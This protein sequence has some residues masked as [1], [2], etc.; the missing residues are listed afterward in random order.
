MATKLSFKQQHSLS[1][2]QEVSARIRTRYPDRVPV[3]VEKAP[4]SDVPDIDK[5]K[6]LVPDITLGKFTY[7]IR[8]HINLTSEKALFFFVGGVVPPNAERMHRIYDQGKDEDGFLYMAYAGENTFG[9]D[10]IPFDEESS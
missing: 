6:Y 7:E 8:K 2:R 4:R 9:D 5:H 10:W 3:I 1:K